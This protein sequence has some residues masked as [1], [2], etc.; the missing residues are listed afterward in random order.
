MYRFALAL[1]LSTPAFAALADTC[2][3]SGTAYDSSGK[4]MRAVVRLV[5]LQTQ[6]AAFSA[7]DEHAVFN[8]ALPGASGSHYRLDVVSPPTV[9]TGTHIPTRSILGM[10]DSFACG[11][12]QLAHQDVH[13]QVD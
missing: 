12:G 13:A 6:Q 7:T 3:V 5:D 2:S 4:P 8:V 1:V 10:S 9:V 11:G